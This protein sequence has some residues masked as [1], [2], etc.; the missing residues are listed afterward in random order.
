M[1]HSWLPTELHSIHGF[2]TKCQVNIWIHISYHKLTFKIEINISTHISCKIVEQNN[3][4][5][6]VKPLHKSTGFINSSPP[7]AAYT[8]QWTGSTFVQVMACRL[9]GAIPLP[10]P[11][12]AYCQL[13][14]REQISV[15]FESEF[16]YFHW[17]KCIWKYRSVGDESVLTAI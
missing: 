9:F 16:L 11:M 14:S 3:G 12:L 2:S 13:A 8:R 15:K 1:L 7:I 5:Q 10:E 6:Q 17:R 4:R